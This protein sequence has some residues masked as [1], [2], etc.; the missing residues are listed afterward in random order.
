VPSVVDE[1]LSV[2]PFFDWAVCP[3]PLCLPGFLGD[4]AYFPV[5]QTSINL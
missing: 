4:A 2:L 3:Q 5:A 1:K